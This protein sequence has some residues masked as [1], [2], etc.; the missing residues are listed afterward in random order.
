MCVCVVPFCLNNLLYYW[1]FLFCKIKHTNKC[2]DCVRIHV[3]E[4]DDEYFTLIVC[5]ILMD[6]FLYSYLSY[7]VVIHFI[8]FIYRLVD[9]F[10]L[11]FYIVR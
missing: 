7:F 10:G 1:G 11:H 8:I 9:L 2:D 6:T 4:C 3:G 5:H